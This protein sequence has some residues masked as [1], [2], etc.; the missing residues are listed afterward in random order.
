[1]DMYIRVASE[2]VFDTLCLWLLI[3]V[4]YNRILHDTNIGLALRHKPKFPY[5]RVLWLIYGYEWMNG[6]HTDINLT[7]KIAVFR[8]SQ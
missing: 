6:I 8:R 3:C 2:Y 5:M 4:S 1:M 7:W